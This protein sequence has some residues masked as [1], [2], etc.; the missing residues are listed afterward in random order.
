[1]ELDQTWTWITLSGYEKNLTEL[2]NN[3]NI[4]FFNTTQTQYLTTRQGI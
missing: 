2:V 3:I 1:M 4:S